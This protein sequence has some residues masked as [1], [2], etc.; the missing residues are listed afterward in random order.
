VG[1]LA[2]VI[3]SPLAAAAFTN[4]ETTVTLAQTENIQWVEQLLHVL[5]VRVVHMR[6]EQQVRVLCVLREHILRRG[7][8][9][10]QPCRVD[11]LRLPVGHVLRRRGERATRHNNRTQRVQPRAIARA[12]ARQDTGG[13]ARRPGLRSLKPARRR[14]KGTLWRMR[15]AHRRRP[16]PLART[17]GAREK[18]PVWRPRG[19]TMWL[20]LHRQHNMRVPKELTKIKPGS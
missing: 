18:R 1:L 11:T 4:L 9:V 6:L 20:L 8:Q 19:G 15:E 3:R 7:H 5:R 13:A 10:V 12:S 14:P 2:V 17:R 16:V